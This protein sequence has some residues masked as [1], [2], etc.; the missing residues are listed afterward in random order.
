MIFL[1]PEETREDSI[2]ETLFPISE[3]RQPVGTEPDPELIEEETTPNTTPDPI[4]DKER[5]TKLDTPSATAKGLIDEDGNTGL[6][7]LNKKNGYVYFYYNNEKTRLS[8]TTIPDILTAKMGRVDNDIYFTL[9]TTEDHKTD[10]QILKLQFTGSEFDFQELNENNFETEILN[11]PSSVTEVTISPDQKKILWLERSDDELIGI[12]ADWDLTDQKRI[13]STSHKQWQVSW[14]DP[15]KVFLQTN[16]SGHLPGFI[17]RLDLK[18]NQIERI[19]GD[20]KGLTGIPSPD[21]QKIA[22]SKYTEP[23]QFSSFIYQIETGVK[24]Q[25]PINILTDKCVW[26]SDSVYLY[27]GLSEEITRGNYPD[28]WY[29]GNINFN[30]DIWAYTNE[31]GKA[32]LFYELQLNKDLNITDLQLSHNDGILLFKNKNTGNLFM[33]DIYNYESYN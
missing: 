22:Y 11:L 13:F 10:Y 4:F 21:G 27:C 25:L 31:T 1:L 12:T 24:K 18:T 20:K 23:D 14:P 30:D 33:W 2:I 26:G 17:Y 28:D 5:L 15:D 16:S 8:N 32:F 3:Q 19:I 7:Y 29:K 9:T 6:I